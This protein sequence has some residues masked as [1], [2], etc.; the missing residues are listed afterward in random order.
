[1]KIVYFPLIRL[2]SF[3]FLSIQNIC[4]HSVTLPYCKVYK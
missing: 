1:M 2:L 3:L 4:K